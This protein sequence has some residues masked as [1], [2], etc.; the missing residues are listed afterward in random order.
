M[1]AL[2]HDLRYA[3]RALLNRPWFSALAV[4]T[5]AIGI[6][7]N[8]VAFSAMNALFRKPMRFEGAREL[9]WIQ[10]TG[11]TSA[12]NHSSL[13][14][15][16]DLAR[17]N[18]TFA[19]IIAEARLPLSMR[20]AGSDGSPGGGASEQVWGLLVSGNYLST[21]RARPAH[22]VNYFVTPGVV[23]GLARRGKSPTPASVRSTFLIVPSSLKC[24]Y[25][26][27]TCRCFFAQA[28][29]GTSSQR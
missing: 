1:D 8:T 15:Y 22:E 28:A 29:P 26:A 24:R 2:R 5:L 4:L 21:M 10:T 7:V 3:F 19:S 25:S 9:G 6:G 20:D 23:P 16:L 14:D 11:G 18:R 27:V 13:P 12:Y 17:E